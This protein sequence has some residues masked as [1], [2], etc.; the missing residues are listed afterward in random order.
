M[1]GGVLASE[2]GLGKTIMG[3]GL[4]LSNPAP[5][6]LPKPRAR[7]KVSS[8]GTLV[9]CAVSLVGQWVEEA[10]SKLS[11]PDIKIYAYVLWF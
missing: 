4:L 3:L 5:T 2:M 9:V 6:T 10:K 11:N 8:R 1:R 7:A